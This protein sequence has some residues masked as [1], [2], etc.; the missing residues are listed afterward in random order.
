ML[1]Q[2][3]EI[4]VNVTCNTYINTLLAKQDIID[5]LLTATYVEDS[6]KQQLKDMGMCML[7]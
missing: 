3:L 5:E 1:C 7:P 2:S 6:T 4:E